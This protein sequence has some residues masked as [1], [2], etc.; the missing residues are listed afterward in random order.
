M[1]YRAPREQ[2]EPTITLK[3]RTVVVSQSSASL[4]CQSLLKNA[5]IRMTIAVNNCNV[6]EGGDVHLIKE[7][8]SKLL[9]FG[10]HDH[11][12]SEVIAILPTAKK[13]WH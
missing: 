6:F 9:L 12:F 2:H 11:I 13:G 4:S 1:A 10:T 8:T 7:K 3:V 5:R